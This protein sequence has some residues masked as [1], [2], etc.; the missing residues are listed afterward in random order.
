MGRRKRGYPTVDFR[1]TVPQRLMPMLGGLIGIGTA[2]LYFWLAQG[3]FNAGLTGHLLLGWAF[4]GA[5]VGL[6]GSAGYG[7]TLTPW[8]A[9]V[10]NLRKRVIWW[11]DVEMIRVEKSFP[12][13][14]IVI[15]EFG[16]RRTTLRAPITGFLFWDRRFEEKYH[17]IGRWWLEHR[18]ME[19]ANTG[20]Q[21][22][23]PAALPI[24]D[25]VPPGHRPP[26]GAYSTEHGAHQR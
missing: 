21:D 5:I 19:P 17:T 12:N 15:Y 1:L 22:A 26:S 14:K 3:L 4:G 8:T 13:R 18:M 10:Q 2:Q 20:P 11:P 9:E 25:A 23:P 7:V 24:E 16:G 6:T